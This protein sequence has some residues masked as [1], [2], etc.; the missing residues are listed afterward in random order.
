MGNGGARHLLALVIVAA[1]GLLA[2]CAP[3]PTGGG[4]STTTSTTSTS[5]TSTSTTSTSTTSTT[6]TS[7]T[8]T[9]TT[10]TTIDPNQAPEIAAFGAKYTSG[11]APHTTPFTWS[12]SDPE[13]D[14]LTCELDAD[15]DGTYEITVPG[16]TSASTRA[17]TL[18]TVGTANAT[19]RVSDATKQATAT[20]AIQVDP[21]SADSFDIDTR[22]SGTVTPSQTTIIEAAVSKWEQ[23]I[24]NG[25]AAGSIDPD[26][27]Q[28]LTP[29]A[30]PID[31]V[32]LDVV[33]R[34]ADGVNGQIGQAVVCQY[35]VS[36]GVFGVPEYTV[37]LLDSDDIAAQEAAGRLY[38]VVLHELAHGLG[39]GESVKWRTTTNPL[40]LGVG[41][42]DPRFSGATA[43]AEWQALGGTG[44]IPVS[45]VNHWRESTFGNEL[46]TPNA[47]PVSNPLS[48][49]TIA[50]MRDIG[51]TVDLGQAD[52]YSLPN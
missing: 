20:V 42:P 47:D 29:P 37:I 28:G 18:T 49:M 34:P 14:P 5:T 15:G 33:V 40:L 24:V 23:I 19:L 36:S 17:A 7:T 48:R 52:P 3:P 35:R 32:F 45:G 30:G 27:C 21:S 22:I 43:V 44:N 11:P 39:F 31:D 16:C 13:G 38:S 8:T 41:G 51:Y 26:S 10:T 4:G 12:I 50:S 2:A 9:S 25:A 1:G 6:T 46:M